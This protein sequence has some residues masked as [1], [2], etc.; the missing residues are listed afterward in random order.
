[1]DARFGS[2]L[3]PIKGA[4]FLVCFCVKFVRFITLDAV[5]SQWFNEE[6]CMS[7]NQ[8]VKRTS[9]LTSKNFELK[10]SYPQSP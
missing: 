3:I 10:E 2:Y 7:G 1:M 6:D 4:K 9:Q 8:K 5:Y